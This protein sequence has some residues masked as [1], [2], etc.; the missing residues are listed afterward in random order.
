MILLVSIYRFNG[1]YLEISILTN[2][3]EGISVII[4]SIV[5]QT[6]CHYYGFIIS[7]SKKT[8]DNSF[9]SLLIV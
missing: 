9:Y 3:N 6:Q 5:L 8:L 1:F 2:C 4:S 7:R